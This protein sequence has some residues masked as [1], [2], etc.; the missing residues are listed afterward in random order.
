[1][2]ILPKFISSVLSLP[3]PLI[4]ASILTACLFGT[5]AYRL[6]SHP[7]AGIPGPR[8]AGVTKLW[9]AWHVRKGKSHAFLPDLHKKY[10]RVVRIA[11]NWVL[12]CDEGFV[13]AAY[14]AGSSFTKDAWYQVCA[15]PDSKYKGVERFD[16]LTEHD[17]E[18]YRH[19]RRA[20][21]PAYSVAGMEKHAGIISTY[22]DV[23]ADR[24]KGLRGEKVD[25]QEWTHIFALDAL[26]RLTLSKS[27]DYTAKG[28]D[29]GN[30]L[31]SD[32]HWAYFTVVGLFP[33][34]VDLT[35]TF[36][37]A[38][39]YTTLLVARFFGLPVPTSLPIF[40]FAVP[41]VLE[42]LG[43]LEST[44]TAKMPMD[45][46]GLTTSHVDDVPCSKELYED[47]GDE[48]DLLATLMK[49]HADREARFHPG[50]VLG[51][52]LTNFGAGHDTMTITLTSMLYLVAKHP[53]VQ[54]RLVRAM[55]EKGITDKSSYTDM[56]TSV[57]YFL[58]VLKESLRI[59]S[60]IGFMLP[61]V[62]PPGGVH[63]DGHSIPSGTT[64]ASSMYATHH[65]AAVFPSPQTFSPERWLADGS[66]AKK[67]EIARMDAVWMGFGGGSRS[68]PGQHLA[69]F[70]VVKVLAR[71]LNEF[72]IEV[73]GEVE[74]RGWFSAHVGGVGVRFRERR[75]GEGRGSEY[76]IGI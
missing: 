21:G 4:A 35:Q 59:F 47:A 64:V 75:G 76:T 16:L 48:Q 55:R 52:T 74:V 49:L 72:E 7:L 71:L 1:M 27:L 62:V 56:V 69:R 66:E 63:V 39:N 50:W 22:I 5:V 44:S 43:A 15:A 33:W 6:T 41:N 40:Q 9:L 29:G 3:L 28:N 46:P 57:P 70:C 45:R 13:R 11:P 61:R 25:L 12:V 58:A 38:Y 10:G 65:D 34:L 18:R 68:C 31:A 37:R 53:E 20:I 32:K 60:P 26:A 23:Y 36:P 17:K 19:Q 8:L 30:M 67:K 73:E 24:V 51:I 42:R 14:S 2:T 54:N